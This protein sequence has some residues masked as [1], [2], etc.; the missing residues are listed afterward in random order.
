MNVDI[1]VTEDG[2]HTLFSP[3]FG[4]IYHSRKG[5][6][7]ESMHVY[8]R[9]G[10][11]ACELSEVH[12][13]EMGFGSGLNALLSW[14]FAEENKLKIHYTGLELFPVPNDITSQI[15]Y[16]LLLPGYEEKFKLLHESHWGKA[17][18][19]S[20]NFTITKLN[21]SLSDMIPPQ[22]KFNVVYFDAFAP[23]RQPEL[24]TGDIFKKV[25]KM[26][27]YGGILTTYCSK[28][29]VRKDMISAGLRVEKLQ[30]PQGKRDMVRAWKDNV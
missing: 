17:V 9:H 15:N 13:F 27:A 12:V 22:T 8:I 10:L 19:L 3:R 28:T 6:I 29:V 25:Y 21:E 30:G 4:E 2:S 23:T 11:A 1:I 5:A 14:K 26:M 20:E 18:T 7:A 16:G 24:W